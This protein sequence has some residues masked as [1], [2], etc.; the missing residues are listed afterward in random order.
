[1]ILD[2][3]TLLVANTLVMGLCGGLLIST[4]WR[5]RVERT[6]LWMGSSLLITAAGIVITALRGVGI[7]TLSIILGNALVL[8]AVAMYWA[9][10]RAFVG[11]R[12]PLVLLL[13]GA[14]LWC[15]LGLWPVFL[16]STSLR[17]ALFCGLVVLYMVATL[18]ELLRMPRKQGLSIVPATLLLGS[19]C[20]FYLMRLLADSGSP[21]NNGSSAFFGWVLIESMLYSVGAGFIA[22]SLVKERAEVHYRAAS[23]T[24]PLTGIGNR[25]AFT[26]SVE[27]LLKSIAEQ[28]RTLAL[29]VCDLDNF[30]QINDRLGHPVG[31]WVIQCFAQALRDSLKPH[32]IFGR[33]GGEEFA[34]LLETDRDGAVVVAEAIRLAFKQRVQEQGTMS[35]SIG[36]ACASSARL[37]ISRLLSLADGALY[38]AKNNGRDRVV[39]ADLYAQNDVKKTEQVRRFR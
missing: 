8:L 27:N 1:M 19:H 10:M 28:P 37:D 35:A 20:G 5:G 34:C 14:S 18:F 38:Q 39:V 3:P 15:L 25:R 6:L 33:I 22:L 24:D 4:W 13:A 31:D 11:R 12:V 21:L 29:L 30:K 16:Q 26:H 23:L 2:I 32:D 7:D 36:I 17:L 9:G